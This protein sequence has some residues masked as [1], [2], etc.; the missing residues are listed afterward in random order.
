MIMFV[1]RDITVSKQ[2][3]TSL[4][5]PLLHLA[6][7]RVAECD[8][9]RS[10]CRLNCGSNVVK[11]LVLYMLPVHGN[12][13]SSN[14]QLGSSATALCWH[15]TISLAQSKAWQQQCQRCVLWVFVH[16]STALY[17]LYIPHVLHTLHNHAMGVIPHVTPK[18]HC[19]AR[20]RWC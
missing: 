19:K 2:A 20:K 4:S 11:A 6:P 14:T 10:P 5:C 15:L 13:S 7:W 18:Y 3:T 1:L 16:G 17:L 8:L 9:H 12:H